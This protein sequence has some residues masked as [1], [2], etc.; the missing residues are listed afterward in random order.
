MATTRLLSGCGLTH[1]TTS[2]VGVRQIARKE[3]HDFAVDDYA[4]FAADLL[5]LSKAL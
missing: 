2:L 1:Y 3:G 5:T 4:R